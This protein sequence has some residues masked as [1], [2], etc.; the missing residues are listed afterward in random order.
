MMCAVAMLENGCNSRCWEQVGFAGE[1]LAPTCRTPEP[2]PTR[3]Q[4]TRAE[5]RTMPGLPGVAAALRPFA[6]G[7]ELAALSGALPRSARDAA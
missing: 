4:A 2:T 1:W 3:E 6:A 5:M 7:A